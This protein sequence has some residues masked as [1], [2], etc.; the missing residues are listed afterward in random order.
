MDSKWIQCK[1]RN[2][3]ISKQIAI[4]KIILKKGFSIETIKRYAGKE[5]ADIEKTNAIM[6]SLI[7][8]DK[9]FMVGRLG[10]TEM[11]AINSYLQ[12]EHFPH[13]DTRKQSVKK[14]C[15]TAGFFPNNIEKGRRFVDLML[16]SCQFIDLCGIWNLYMEDYV[17]NKYSP[18]TQLTLLDSLEPWNMEIDEHIKPWSK[19]LKG[20]KILV[21]HPFAKTIGHQYN[22]YREKIFERKFEAD[23]ILP[24]FELITLKAVQTINFNTENIEYRDWFEALDS[25]IE[26]CKK[27]NFDIAIIGCGAYGFPLAAAIKQMG[28]GAIHLGGATQILFGIIG[29]RWETD[30]YKLIIDQIKNEYWTRPILEEKPQNADEIEGGCYW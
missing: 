3:F 28:K 27:I 22:N 30:G 6:A 16:E 9:P 14:M 4:K 24:E 10:A 25:M 11:N 19:A 15:K 20:K 23:D 17:L 13:K 8:S 2:E 7:N 29:K 21:I 5:V 1:L 12:F 18:N 26:Q